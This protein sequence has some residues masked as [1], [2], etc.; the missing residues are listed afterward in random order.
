M[1]NS[2]R[3]FSLLAAAAGLLC[4]ATLA[5]AHATT[6]TASFDNGGLSEAPP[7]QPPFV[8]SGT[9]TI[10]ND[11]GDGTFAL[12]S[13]GGFSMSFTFGS[14]TFSTG[15][16]ATPLSEILVVLSSTAGGQQLQFSNTNAFGSG[17]EGGSIDLAPSAGG[18]LSFEPPGFG[19]LNLYQ[20][21]D[22]AGD[23]LSG[24][25]IALAAVP[26]PATLALFGAG[27]VG[28]GVI[29]R[30]RKAD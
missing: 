8:G 24:N 20:E 23:S 6:F 13:L 10:A 11:P 30:R 1:A 19:G 7:P 16:I 21:T 15:D 12:T 25:Y 14:T 2:T 17:P 9:I 26:E 28:L 22:A 29:R 4:L 18:F 3:Q 27:L 5:P